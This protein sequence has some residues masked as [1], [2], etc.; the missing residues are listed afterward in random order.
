MLI[1]ILGSA[2]GGGFP[3]WNCN[4]PNCAGWRQGRIKARSRTQ[5]SI[6]VTPD[7]ERWLLLNTSPEILQQLRDNPSVQPARSLRDTGIAAIVLM[8][9]QVDH[10]AGLC[11]LREHGKP[12][13]L[14]CTAQVEQELRTTWPLF[15]LLS[16]Y[17]GVDVH[18]LP[19]QED[20]IAL[21]A[22]PNLCLQACPLQ[23]NA[24]PF[25]PRRDAPV[26]GDNIGL[27]VRDV[28]SGR[29]IFYAPGLGARDARVH[30]AMREADCVLVDGTFW[31]DDE[32]IRLGLS[33]RSAREMGHMPLH[34]SGGMLEWLEELP[35][36]KRKIL[37]HIN[38]TNPILDEGSAE[39]AELQRRQIE[40]AYDGMEIEL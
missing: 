37:I 31:T 10:T 15:A 30:A 6:A 20:G 3:Q 32:M 38:N 24:P 2:A 25:S 18:R 7:K 9:A 21:P 29:S 23:S 16:H 36:S 39:Y 13:P 22:L 19:L 33:K 28:Q 34:G 1:R 11:M 4:C 5:S 8:D 17:C 12:L 26:P 14:W 35:A 27:T 40:V